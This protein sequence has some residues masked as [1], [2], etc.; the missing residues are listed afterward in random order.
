MN[1]GTVKVLK[2]SSGP[3]PKTFRKF[4]FTK[5][6]KNQYYWGRG[7]RKNWL[8][9][10]SKPSQTPVISDWKSTKGC[11]GSIHLIRAKCLDSDYSLRNGLALTTFSI[12]QHFISNRQP[13]CSLHSSIMHPWSYW[14]MP[15]IF[16]KKHTDVVYYKRVTIIVLLRV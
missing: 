1:F 6:L 15:S 2:F 8:S 11:L 16:I 13:E 3:K 10:N 14:R 9:S 12:K 4:Y 7:K 5:M